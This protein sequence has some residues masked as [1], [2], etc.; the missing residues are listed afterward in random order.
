MSRCLVLLGFL[1]L[2][3]C[4]DSD[5]GGVS[6]QDAGLIDRNARDA[7]PC[8]DEGFSRAED[9]RCLCNNDFACGSGSVCEGG[10]CLDGCR[11]DGHCQDTER[12]EIQ[13]NNTFGA[14]VNACPNGDCPD[15]C[16]NDQDCSDG[17]HCEGRFCVPNCQSNAECAQGEACVTSGRCVPGC[18]SPE[19]CGGRATCEEAMCQCEPAQAFTVVEVEDQTAN[20]G[21][22]SGDTLSIT[23]HV[24]NVDRDLQVGL[25]V[26]TQN[27]SRVGFANAQWQGLEPDANGFR[28][29]QSGG[30]GAVVTFTGLDSKVT[31]SAVAGAAR[32]PVRVNAELVMLGQQGQE[33]AA[34]V[35]NSIGLA[36]LPVFGADNDLANCADMHGAHIVQ[37]MTAQASV[38]ASEFD[39]VERDDMSWAG[40]AQPLVGPKLHYCIDLLGSGQL[41]LSSDW[42]GEA[43]VAVQGQFLFEAFD[44]AQT[45]VCQNAGDCTRP[46]VQACID[47]QCRER[48]QI[49]M[50]G[51]SERALLDR[52]HRNAQVET[53]GPEACLNGC[54][55]DPVPRN[56]PAWGAGDLNLTGFLRW[57]QRTDLR[58]SVLATGDQIASSALFL[59]TR[60]MPD[61]WLSKT[62]RC[63]YGSGALAC[64]APSEQGL[65]AARGICS[66]P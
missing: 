43:P 31:L 32:A 45:E 48:L 15:T 23:I 61:W 17:Q 62:C 29:L 25:I 56:Q 26:R 14:C 46:G 57:G 47:G 40:Q 55:I 35:P 51:A 10:Q 38:P 27:V 7:G 44:M 19:D 59:Q 54:Q 37:L 13:G 5:S 8:P 6:Y 34:A 3:G 12:C 16:T 9:G 11:H 60:E 4:G 49:R 22:R 41:A 20:A 66:E 21:L 33:C 63:D 53:T 36:N 24:P 2:A 28:E 42:R 50:A 52:E 1:A 65:D 30:H 39:G 18:R 64:G 58:M